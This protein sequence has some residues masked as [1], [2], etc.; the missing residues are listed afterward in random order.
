MV[1][2][3]CRRSFCSISRQAIMTLFSKKRSCNKHALWL[4]LVLWALASICHSST[5]AAEPPSKPGDAG[6]PAS[7][8]GVEDSG[9]FFVYVNEDR[10]ATVDFKWHADGAF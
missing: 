7:L 4:T 3:L 2:R 10:V 9:K 8:S 1:M 6:F 5:R